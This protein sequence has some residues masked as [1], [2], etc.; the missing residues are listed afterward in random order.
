M[1]E[2]KRAKAMHL[3]LLMVNGEV[4]DEFRV[5]PVEPKDENAPYILQFL[6]ENGT[7]LAEAMKAAAIEYLNTP[8]GREAWYGK[9]DEVMAELDGEDYEP[10]APKV[11]Y[12]TVPDGILERHGL[13]RLTGTEAVPVSFMQVDEPVAKFSDAWDGYLSPYEER[14]D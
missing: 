6:V 9:N 4:R 7:D 1:E 12:D 3:E 2:M 11:F 8:E 5:E 10:L 14:I 13:K